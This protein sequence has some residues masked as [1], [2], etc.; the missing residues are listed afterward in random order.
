[1]KVY[2]VN[3]KNIRVRFAPAPTGM[4]HLGNIRT[5]L[6]NY[7]FAI[8]HNATLVLR[9]EDTDPKRNFDPAGEIIIQ[10][11]QWLGID[12]SEG[13]GKGGP[14]K[15]YAQSERMEIYAE[16]L[17]QLEKINA[18][19]K[20]FCTTEEL[21]KKRKRQQALKMPP[22]YDRTCLKLSGDKIQD[23]INNN[24]SFVWRVKFNHEKSIVINDL[25]HG[26]I[27]FE[28]K[29]FSDFP[30][31][32]QDGS[33]TFMFANFV[34]DMAM[35]ISHVFRGEDHLSNTA[36]QAMLYS[37][38]NTELPTFWHMPILC[39]TD[40]KKLSK[41]DFGFSLR[42]LKN[43]GFLPEAIC[44]YLAIIGGSFEK[45]IMTLQELATTINFSAKGQI[46]YDIEKLKWVN[47]KWI[48]QYSVKKLV[49]LVQPLL[50]KE[51]PSAEKTSPE[52][53]AKLIESVQCEMVT[54]KDFAPAL[55]FY[56]NK[57]AL[58]KTDVQ[59]CVSSN[60]V[61][62]VKNIITN[63]MPQIKKPTDFINIIKAEAKAAE[64]PLKSIFWFLRLALTGATKGH[65]INL[66]I[67]MLGTEESKKRIVDGLKFL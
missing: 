42:D 23:N 34:D 53:I 15:P 54:L 21:D 57:P 46:K 7:L 16:K 22:R 11:L 49:P 31:T 40:G 43:D 13:Q 8:K 38:F 5:A 55:S 48:S 1:M 41:R 30:I 37:F 50:N 14:Y 63:Q 12:H 9:L 24:V 35:N 45:E 60:H 44:N 65:A 66:L 56:F 6:M 51:Y 59:S 61:N 29:H 28:L 32:R 64:V 47:H 18:I 20:C 10:D 36:G 17:N 25:A 26:K 52:D 3:L 2:I 67:E 27:T 58:T 4:M 19:Y 39:N 62:N 33:Y